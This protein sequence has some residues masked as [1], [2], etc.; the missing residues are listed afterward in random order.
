MLN[1][2]YK[3]FYKG[4]HIMKNKLIS[5]IAVIAMILVMVPFASFA[6]ET[7]PAEPDI[8]DGTTTSSTASGGQ[9]KDPTG[10]DGFITGSSSSTSKVKPT[11]NSAS[12]T[13][14]KTTKG[15]TTK[16]ASGITTAAK[17]TVN[18]PDFK[19]VK[20]KKQ[21]KIKY[22]K[23]VGSVGFQ[24]RYRIKGK[25]KVKT[26]KT[27]KNT[28]KVVKNL[29]KGTYKVQVRAFAKGKAYGKWSKTK[30]VAVK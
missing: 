5:V 20:G 23:V 7:D 13:A 10:N 18:V 25:W 29:K 16:K 12:T 26:F 22:K 19:L 3:N 8:F 11:A 27:S 24:V 4:S 1:L 6:D 17:A 30:K 15:K 21:F 28:V 14:A 2:I 9:D